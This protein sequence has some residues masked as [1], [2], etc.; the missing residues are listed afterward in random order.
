M[1][2]LIV[3]GAGGK[4]GTRVLALAEQSKSFLTV[5]AVDAFAQ[6][7]VSSLS[8]V[9][10]SADGII[11]F[12]SHLATGELLEYALKTKTPLVSPSTSSLLCLLLPLF[13][14]DFTN[15]KK[16]NINTIGIAMFLKMI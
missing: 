12:S 11:D 16:M 13:H 3:N 10:E 5:A 15:R 2:R 9:Q 6:G 4:M 7:F 8:E 1:I 14:A